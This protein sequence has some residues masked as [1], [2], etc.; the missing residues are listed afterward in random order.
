MTLKDSVGPIVPIVVGE[1]KATTAMQEAILEKGL[2]LQAIRPPTVPEGTSRLRFTVVRGL[3][4]D[5]MDSTI[6]ALSDAGRKYGL[7]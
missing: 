7:I 4:K 6:E 2:F 1:D 5:D 3:T